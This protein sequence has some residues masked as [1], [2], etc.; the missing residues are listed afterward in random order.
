MDKITKKMQELNFEELYIKLKYAE[1][2]SEKN[3][4]MKNFQIAEQKYL[5]YR[6][7]LKTLKRIKEIEIEYSDKTKKIQEN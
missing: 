4:A 1:T 5:G 2:E 3:K 6:N 7:M